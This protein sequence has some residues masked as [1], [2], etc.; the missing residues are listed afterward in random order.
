MSTKIAVMLD[1]GHVRVH[2]KSAGKQYDPDYIEKIGLACSVTG[3]TIHRIMY[4]DCPPFNGTAIL[5]VSGNKKAF[6]GSDAWLKTLSYKDLFCIRLGVLKFRGYVINN[7]KI[8]Y[9][10]GQPLTDAD[11]HPEFEQ[12]GVDMR[13]G[14]DMA[15]LSAN[16]SVDLI[17]LATNDTDCIPAIEVCPARWSSD[18]THYGTG[19]PA[20]S[21]V[22]G[23]LRLSS[24]HRV[25]SIGQH[26]GPIWPSCPGN[27]G[28]P[29]C[30]GNEESATRGCRESPQTPA[31]SLAGHLS[32]FQHLPRTRYCGTGAAMIHTDDQSSSR[33]NALATFAESFAE[34]EKARSHSLLIEASIQDLL[35][36]K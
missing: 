32:N 1:G 16:R 26:R 22:A 18:R 13:I 4:Y 34:L 24:Q 31:G 7:N 10:P 29:D 30:P 27:H 11:F 28:I 8:P 17:A 14:I 33:N 3:E 21:R 20:S 9:T 19:L 15:N 12:K 2:A 6:A 36:P 25:A 35:R 23:A 5:P